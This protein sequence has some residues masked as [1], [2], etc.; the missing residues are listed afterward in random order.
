MYTPEP[1]IVKY[2]K[3]YDPHLGARW[4]ANISRWVVTWR[5]KYAYR[6]QNDDG[7]YRP[8]DERAVTHAKL[9][10]MWQHRTARDYLRVM[11][12]EQHRMSAKEKARHMDDF[13]QMCV[14]DGYKKLVGVGSGGGPS[15]F[16]GWSA[17]E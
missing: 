14:E 6:C 12:E 8:L 10:D 5:G 11:D 9:N 3:E 16:N 1:R 17:P 13:R 7:S 2:L 4:D 15:T